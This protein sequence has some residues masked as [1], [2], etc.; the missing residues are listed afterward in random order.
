MPGVREANPKEPLRSHDITERPWQVVG[1]DLFTWNTQNFIVIVDYY[2]RFFE[3]ERLTSCTSLAV[4][5]KLKSAFARHGIAETVI[6]DNGQCYSAE[7]FRRFANAWRFTH[8][9]TSPRFPQSNGLA[10]KT[11][12]TAK[13]I[14]DKA[15]A[16]NT[17]LPRSAGIQKHP[18]G[19]P[20]VTCSTSDEPTTTLHT[21]SNQQ[22]SAATDS[23]PES[24]SG[25]VKGM[26]T[27]PTNLL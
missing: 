4:I 22:A 3:M 6:S 19:Q 17:D 14:L 1:T 23:T 2:S 13:R 10:E 25:Q 16:G 12:Q 24:H 11:V 9:T 18:S 21:S 27:P 5:N 15:K 26:S 7:E 20:P 8:S